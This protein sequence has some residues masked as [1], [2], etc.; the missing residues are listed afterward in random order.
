MGRVEGGPDGVRCLGW[1][2]QLSAVV[3]PDHFA[4]R[5]DGRRVRGQLGAVVGGGEQVGTE[6]AWFDAHPELTRA[7]SRATLQSGALLRPDYYATSDLFSAAIEVGQQR[8]E[9]RPDVDPR[10]VGRLLIDGYLG[11][12]YRWAVEDAAPS[13][14]RDFVQTVDLVVE[15]IRTRPA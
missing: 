12:V 14:E 5:A 6:V 2:A 7:L 11:V 10:A 9:I 8:G 13:P 15:G 4:G 3:A 1:I